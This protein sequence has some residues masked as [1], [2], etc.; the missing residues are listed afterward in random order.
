MTAN[1]NPVTSFVDLLIVGA[2]PAGLVLALWASK[3]GMKTRIIDEK[4]S[5]VATGRADGLHSRTL[6]ILH[7]F[8]AAQDII[9]RA[10]HINEICSWNPDPGNEYHIRRTQ[11]TVAQ[12]CHLSRFTQSG[13]N[14]GATEEILENKIRSEGRISVERNTIPT[15][16]R[17][18][19][20]EA[21]HHDKDV[22]PIFV[23]LRRID[24][25]E[26]SVTC[27]GEVVGNE[28]STTKNGA[29]ISTGATKDN[30]EIVRAK[31]L[32]GCDG[33]HSWIRHQ[34][35]IH[36]EGEKTDTHFGVMDVVP[37]TDFPDI[38]ISCVIHSKHGSVMTVPRENRL[39]RLYVQLGETLRGNDLAGSK[40]V[41]PE[42]IL[43][44]AKKMFQPY[45]IDFKICDWH[46]VYTVGQR[47]APTFDFKNRIFLAGDSVHTH[48]PTLGQ[49]MNVSMQDAYNLGWK[50]GMV[51]TGVAQPSILRTYTQER[52]NV[53]K[54]L[55]ELDKRMTKFYSMGP[56]KESQDYQPFRDQFSQFISGVAITYTPSEL[57]DIASQQDLADNIKL[58]QR[59]PSYKVVCNAEGN[60]VH[61]SDML[62]NNGTWRILVFAGDLESPSQFEK[63]QQLG[64]NL[65]S[66]LGRYKTADRAVF[67]VFL[68]HA[69]TREFNILRLHPVYHPW[70]DALGWDYWKVF[71]NDVE[72]FEPCQSPYDEYGV[73]K[74]HGCVVTLRPDQHVS[75]IGPMDSFG[76]LERF[77]CRILV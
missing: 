21:S 71:S 5:R 1:E 7:N 25:D 61:L 77:F 3:F 44:Y 14:Q 43:G 74:K 29:N 41:T 28:H 73:S 30:Q 35:G 15:A 55:I 42:R 39:V 46:S 22:Y 76:D 53:A 51:I 13:L 60:L 49:G 2:G 27:D 67:E 59:L 20:K 19:D 12:P 32:V 4:D 72:D 57:I 37:L 56:S 8:G 16:L 50:L 18:D 69:G 66:L 63:V 9:S 64:V 31:Y 58:G 24:P 23:T 45:H 52:W 70:N 26:T 47:L 68:I 34:V 33:A 17:F 54:A 75:Y 65:E 10:Y 36:M 40:D 48:S 11:R 6:E 62:P 38:R